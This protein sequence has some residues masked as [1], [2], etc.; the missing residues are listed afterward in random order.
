MAGKVHSES[1]KSRAYF[2]QEFAHKLFLLL[3][4]EILK[5]FVSYRV[6]TGVPSFI[7]N[8][9]II[10][11]LSPG[12]EF[13]Q[14]GEKEGSKGGKKIIRLDY[15]RINHPF[16]FHPGLQF[17]LYGSSVFLAQVCYFLHL[18]NPPEIANRPGSL[19][20]ARIF[21]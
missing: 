3:S 20:A 6:K 12:R 18:S 14:P 4:I 10:D 1:K 11:A 21:S 2:V 5:T 19:S 8:I 17:G 13:A 9:G 15:N 16:L 7:L